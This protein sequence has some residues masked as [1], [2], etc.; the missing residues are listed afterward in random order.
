MKTRNILAA[1]S[2]VAATLLTSAFIIH[3][4]STTPLV[5]NKGF[6]VVE[7]YT[8]EGCSSCPPADEVAAKLQ[9]ESPDKPIY[10]LAFH[11][12]YWD[13]PK[14]KDAFI[15]GE[16]T[17]R[18]NQYAHW[19][20]ILQVYTP[21]V[22]VNGKTEL[23]GSEE[24]KLRGIIAADLDAPAANQLT[25]TNIK[26]DPK[27]ASLQY[28]V[29]GS[30]DDQQLVLAL[31][32]KHAERKIGGG[33]NSGRTISHVQIV[34]QLKTVYARRN[35]SASINLPKDFEASGYELIAFLQNSVTG[36]I[37]GAAKQDFPSAS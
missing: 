29:Q 9:Q 27:K 28:Q 7:L 23:V 35:G 8:S 18:Q 33:E 12:D 16:F 3:K 4:H 19:L 37:T 31:V 11:V 25:L 22:F 17:D 30:T 15:S 24:R 34:R 1:A 2:L 6:A 36:E 20:K 10:V 32:Q 5:G 26:T 13:G 14:W 21:Q